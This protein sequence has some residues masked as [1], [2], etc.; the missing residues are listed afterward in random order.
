MGA[1]LRSDPSSAYNL[2]RLQV[3]PRLPSLQTPRMPQLPAHVRGRMPKVPEILHVCRESRSVG[4]DHYVIGFDISR[5]MSTSRADTDVDTYTTCPHEVSKEEKDMDVYWAPQKDIVSLVESAGW[6][7]DEAVAYVWG[8]KTGIRFG[9]M[10]KVEMSIVTLASCGLGETL[11][12]D[13][14]SRLI[15]LLPSTWDNSDSLAEAQQVANMTLKRA[16]LRDGG[17]DVEFQFLA[18]EDLSS[19][20]RWAQ[21]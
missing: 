19:S 20:S 12:W 18:I 16:G 4:L 1:R 8:G 5:L 6:K 15:V 7:D 17:V 21:I 9:P 3:R 13:S 11:W 14:I 2:L 10:Q